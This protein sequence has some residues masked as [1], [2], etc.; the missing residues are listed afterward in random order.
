MPY[1]IYANVI[2]AHETWGI[3]GFS[4]NWETSD[5][6]YMSRGR[7]AGRKP[8]GLP[9]RIHIFSMLLGRSLGIDVFCTACLTKTQLGRAFDIVTSKVVTLAVLALT[10]VCRFRSCAARF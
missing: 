2:E 6:P 8:L 3:A 10:L 1:L 7:S 4:P 9:T 5:L